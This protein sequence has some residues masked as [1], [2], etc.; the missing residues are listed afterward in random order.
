[1]VISNS[2]DSKRKKK[3]GLS[4]ICIFFGSIL[5]LFSIVV[6]WSGIL[7]YK[8]QL[9][10]QDWP[11]TN[12]TVSFVEEEIDSYSTPGKAN[13]H[14]YTYYDIHYDYV[15]N[16]KS[17]SGVIEDVNYSMNIG[18][19]LAIK[20]NPN[21]PEESTDILEPSRFFIIVG[22]IPGVIGITL[23]V[24]CFVLNKKNKTKGNSIER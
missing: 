7:S 5:L 6:F 13:H 1:M 19:S 16:G 11:T 12:A 18:D 4:A 2:D 15:V 14:S 23:I 21:A 9:T 8:A 17:Y 20:Y 3:N 10:Q 22:G 24:L